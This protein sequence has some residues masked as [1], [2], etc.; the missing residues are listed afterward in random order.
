[1]RASQARGIMRRALLAARAR[2][3][4][5]VRRVPRRRA[6]RCAARAPRCCAVRRTTRPCSPRPPGLPAVLA[7]AAYDGPVREAVVAFKDHGR[8]SL[9]THLGD[10]LARSV[11]AALLLAPGP[12]AGGAR[13]G[14]R[15]AGVGARARRRPRARARATALPR[16]SRREGVR[17]S[18]RPG[19]DL[20]A[21]PPR[22]GRPRPRR[23]GGQPGGL[24]GAHHRGAAP[25]RAARPSSSSTTWSPPAPPSA[26]AAR[27]LRGVRGRTA[28]PRPSWRP[29]PDRLLRSDARTSPRLRPRV[30]PVAPV[31]VRGCVPEGVPVAGAPRGQADASRRRNGPRKATLRR[32]ITVRFRGK[33]CPVRRDTVLAGP[34]EGE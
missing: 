9:R 26:E 25:A 27:A 1:M 13:A 14:A 7:V 10:A 24:D 31:R 21:P 19:A 17:V 3:D 16:C 15:L 5:D 11:A 29:P 2:R 22:P 23:A 4:V 34:G 33:S 30:G 18:R 12:A 6:A 20:R 8:W 32:S 28:W